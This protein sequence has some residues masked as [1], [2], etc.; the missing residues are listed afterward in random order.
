MECQIPP[1]IPYTSSLRVTQKH[2]ASLTQKM[3]Q[4]SNS[5]IIMPGMSFKQ[6]KRRRLNPADI[7][8]LKEAGWTPDQLIT[9]L[10]FNI[11]G[12]WEESDPL[13]LHQFLQS[14]ID[15]LKKLPEAGPFLKPVTV[16]DAVD[17]FDIVSNPMDLSLM[18]V[19]D[20]HSIWS[21]EVCCLE[22]VGI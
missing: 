10:H 12:V 14:V 19:C 6:R 16:E 2:R 21:L 18:E 7:P 4:E 5:H 20:R 15:H 22:T 3:Q 17:Y 1:L 13:S 11:N 8:G 9:N